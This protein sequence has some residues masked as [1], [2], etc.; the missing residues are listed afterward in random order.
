MGETNVSQLVSGQMTGQR[1]TGIPC[2]IR[3]GEGLEC[4]AA[5]N[6]PG[7]FS[8]L[9]YKYTKCH[10]LNQCFPGSLAETW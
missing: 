7:I 6:L 4:L 8:C 2:L 1:P 3:N 10:M 9:P 5:D